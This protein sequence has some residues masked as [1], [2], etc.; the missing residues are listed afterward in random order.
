MCPCL[1]AVEGPE[2]FAPT[3]GV[4][5]IVERHLSPATRGGMLFWVFRKEEERVRK[6]VESTYRS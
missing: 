4:C 2:G 5:L 6:S 3:S 1:I